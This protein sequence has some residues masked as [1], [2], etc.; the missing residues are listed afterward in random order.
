MSR[1]RPTC[2]EIEPELVA[3]GAHEASPSAMRLVE[4]HVAGCAPCRDEL[5]RYR[6]LDQLVTD[7]RHAP[8]PAADPA[9]ARAQLESRLADVRRRLLTYGI[10]PSPLGPILIARSEEGVSMVEYLESEDAA[11]ARLARLAGG[12]AI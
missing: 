10:F 2:R 7:M 9:L 4:E 11:P 12:D 6:A 1:T 5:R 3:V 8:L